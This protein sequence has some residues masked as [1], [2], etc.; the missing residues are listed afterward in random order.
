MF[1]IAQWRL[2]AEATRP[3]DPN[4]TYFFMYL[5]VLSTFRTLTVY[6]LTKLQHSSNCMATANKDINDAEK[7]LLMYFYSMTNVYCR[8]D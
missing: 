6:I 4:T 8:L 3:A 2:P 1:T 5:R 7:G